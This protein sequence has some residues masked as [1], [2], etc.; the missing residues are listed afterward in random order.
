M[1]LVVVLLLPSIADPAFQG[2]RSMGESVT[3][4]Q[5]AVYTAEFVA[6]GILSAF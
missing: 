4:A 2:P 6:L 1:K 3:G 5:Q